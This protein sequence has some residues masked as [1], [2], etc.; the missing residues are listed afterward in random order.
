MKNI[1]RNDDCWLFG[2]GRIWKD[3]ENVDKLS[4]KG[5]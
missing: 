5:H 3:K 4:I 2:D 1:H